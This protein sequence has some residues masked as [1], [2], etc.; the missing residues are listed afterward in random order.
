MFQLFEFEISENSFIRDIQRAV[1]EIRDRGY[2]INVIIIPFIPYN[3]WDYK[4]KSF[5]TESISDHIP[6]PIIISVPRELKHN[7]KTYNKE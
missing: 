2:E 3:N 5:I 7:V 1:D 4:K 6:Y